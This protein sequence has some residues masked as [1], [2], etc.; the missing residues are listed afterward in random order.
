MGSNDLE[1]VVTRG[2][3]VATVGRTTNYLT[4]YAVDNIFNGSPRPNRYIHVC[5]FPGR[6]RLQNKY[7]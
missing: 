4:L 5:V 2:G 7:G 1:N 3:D 6:E